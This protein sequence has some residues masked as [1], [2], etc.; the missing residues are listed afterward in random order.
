MERRSRPAWLSLILGIVIGAGLVLAAVVA[1]I[2]P[3][4]Q[5]IIVAATPS[6]TRYVPPPADARSLRGLPRPL[7]D[8]DSTTPDMLVE[9]ADYS[10]NRY[11]LAYV[12][13]DERTIRWESPPL[14]D[15]TYNRQVIAGPHHVYIADEAR[16]LALA[17]SDGALAWER[18]L[19]DTIT[20]ICRDCLQL[21]GERI[22]A[23]TQDGTLQAFD[24][25]SGAVSW[26]TRFAMQPRQLLV[27]GNLVG[28]LDQPDQEGPSGPTLHLFALADG[29]PAQQTPTLCPNP[30]NPEYPAY[31][32]IYDRIY[33]EPGGRGAL[34]VISR[35]DGCVLRLDARAEVVWRVPTG[36]TLLRDGFHGVPLQGGD[37]VYFGTDVGVVAL[38]VA[39]GVLRT[40]TQA[41]DYQLTPLATHDGMLVV[42]AIRT[43]GTRRDELWGLDA[44]SGERRWGHTLLKPERIEEPGESG[45]WAGWLAGDGFALLQTPEEG[46]LLQ[47]DIL[48]LDSGSAVRSTTIPL[49]QGETWNGLIWS[50]RE[51]WVVADRI[52][53]LDLASAQTRYLWP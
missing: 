12:H 3:G 10:A 25:Q 13:G 42:E 41:E 29:A 38:E 9:L 40:V 35:S 1:G 39:T 8:S 33:Q 36:E 51:A 11:T 53:V 48:R 27:L 14:S 4:R 31:P 50:K 7:L 52:Y 17:R 24:A 30:N 37:S 5:T 47:L 45:G 28:A 15:K 16:L 49:E 20:H 46:G 26:S 23:L 18:N 21:A 34:V 32:G 19:A 44:E 22:V 6:P 2:V 43:R